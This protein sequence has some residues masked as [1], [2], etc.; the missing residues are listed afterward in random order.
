MGRNRR[1]VRLTKRAPDVW[2]SPRFISLFPASS[3]SCSQTL[4]TPAHTQVTQTVGQ[5]V[6][7]IKSSLN[8][9]NKP[10][11]AVLGQVKSRDKNFSMFYKKRL[12]VFRD[13]FDVGFSTICL[14]Y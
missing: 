5:P 6:L 11:S 14:S 7:T 3:F 2:D 9:C 13:T 8:N 10:I 4:S 12:E 1:P